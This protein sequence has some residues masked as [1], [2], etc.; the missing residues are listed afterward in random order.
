MAIAMRVDG[1]QSV[2]GLTF[3]ISQSSKRYDIRVVRV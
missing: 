2:D 3:S 1:Y